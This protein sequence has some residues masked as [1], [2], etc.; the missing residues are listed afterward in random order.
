MQKKMNKDCTALSG[1]LP[2]IDTESTPD[3]KK[4]HAPDI[5]A[6]SFPE[7]GRYLDSQDG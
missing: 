4:Q 2:R 5:E 7:D 3:G 6:E 1:I